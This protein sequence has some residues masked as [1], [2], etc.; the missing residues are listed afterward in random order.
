MS[1]KH[2]G[3]CSKCGSG[4]LLFI[5]GGDGSLDLSEVH[6]DIKYSDRECTFT[7][8]VSQSI[9]ESEW[10]ERKTLVCN[11]LNGRTFS[12]TLDKDPDYYWVGRCTINEYASDKNLHKIV[13][14]ATVAPYKLKNSLTTIQVPGGRNVTCSLW[15]GRRTI[16]PTIT[17]T[18]D[19][20]IT[21]K[22]VSYT[23]KPGTHKI[24]N[25]ELVEGVNTVAVTSVDPVKFTYQEGDL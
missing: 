6:G 9:H 5:P 13:V 15:N 2:S 7:F 8:T 23:V 18:S 25:I 16:V 17:N 14:A 19:A 1:V 24:L 21:F 3:I 11:A 10:E 22:G 4:D 12:I 20:V